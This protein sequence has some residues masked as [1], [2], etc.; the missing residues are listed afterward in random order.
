MMSSTSYPFDGGNFAYGTWRLLDDSTEIPTPHELAK[1]FELCLENGIDVIDTAEIYGTYAVEAAIGQ[2]LQ[3]NPGLKQ[4]VRLVSKAGID[5]PSQEKPHAELPQYDA[6]AK[7]LVAC[8]EKSLRLLGVEALDLFLVHRP[9]WLTPPEDTAAGLTQLLEQ[10]KVRRVGV[11][12]FTIHQFTT[13]NGLLG[14]QLATNQVEFSPFHMNPMYDG[15]FDQCLQ[16]GIRPMAWSPLSGGT[17]F[18]AKNPDSLRLLEKLKELALKYSDAPPDVLIYAWLLAHPAHPTIILGTNKPERIR[19][20][21]LANN[22][23]LQRNDWY[24]IW[25]AATG[26]SVP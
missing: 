16:L 7:N 22:I 4:Q 15:T 10:G 20:S 23:R 2:A 3:V 1:R 5:I 13:L 9:D 6:S 11:S 12:N 14:G 26:K 25:M 18:D 24:A 17:L 21:V 19:T 8:A